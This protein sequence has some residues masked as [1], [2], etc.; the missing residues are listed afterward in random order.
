MTKA[1]NQNDEKL[2]E[3]IKHSH[4]PLGTIHRAYH[5][6]SPSTLK[7]IIENRTIR[8]SD[9]SK[10]NDSLEMEW[11]IS[12][13]NQSL[14]EK[15]QIIGED[16][17]DLIKEAIKEARAKTRFL[18]SC[19][20]R[21][22][23]ILSQW[24]AY[25]DDG[26]GFSIGFSPKKLS[27]WK[28]GFGSVV[29]D[30]KEQLNIFES[31]ILT[32]NNIWRQSSGKSDK[33]FSTKIAIHLL[34]SSCFMKN[35]AFS[36]EKEVRFVHGILYDHQI[37]GFTIESPPIGDRPVE[38]DFCIRNGQFSPYI[39]INFPPDDH[40][41]EEIVLGPKNQNLEIDIRAFTHKKG[42]SIQEINRSL[43]SYR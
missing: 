22:K 9:I 6:C 10:M 36:E 42:L 21:E 23:D 25:A 37:S 30:K 35:S 3:S 18:I 24:R 26:S 41:I 28:P 11:G 5:Y 4:P 16:H 43:A 19:F 12:I 34:F 2:L 32:L 17:F 15:K 14:E 38:I 13:L 8:L 33:K 27:D 29:Y 7:A 31:K 20:S 1:S 39:D 40:F